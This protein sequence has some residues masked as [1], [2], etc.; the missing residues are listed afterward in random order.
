MVIFNNNHDLTKQKKGS[1]FISELSPSAASPVDCLRNSKRKRKKKKRSYIFKTGQ[2]QLSCEEWVSRWGSSA[3]RGDGRKGKVINPRAAGNNNSP[4]LW[5]KT[6]GTEKTSHAAD[7]EQWGDASSHLVK[8]WRRV[9]NVCIFS[10]NMSSTLFPLVFFTSRIWSDRSVS[11]LRTG[12]FGLRKC[13]DLFEEL[14]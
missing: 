8:Y 14:L 3:G 5:C 9:I 12:S 6:W 1:S 11:A 7:R 13:C 2:E 4:L 10:F